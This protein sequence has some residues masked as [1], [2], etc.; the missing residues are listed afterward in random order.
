[1]GGPKGIYRSD[2]ECPYH[3]KNLP[4]RLVKEKS[5]QSLQ[6]PGARRSYMSTMAVDPRFLQPSLGGDEHHLMFSNASQ[7]RDGLSKQVQGTTHSVVEQNCR[8]LRLPGEIRNKIY[9]VIF[10]N[11][12]IPRPH[13]C[14]HQSSEGTEVA[15]Q[16]GAACPCNIRQDFNSA[17]PLLATCRQIRLEGKSLFIERHLQTSNAEGLQLVFAS[18]ASLFRRMASLSQFARSHAQTLRLTLCIRDIHKL[19]LPEVYEASDMIN[20]EAFRRAYHWDNKS[21]ILR[22]WVFAG[23]S[24][25]WR[26]QMLCQADREGVKVISGATVLALDWERMHAKVNGGRSRQWGYG[27]SL[28][29]C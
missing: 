2:D 9:Q 8:L 16:A 27:R 28:M 24:T 10:I 29:G 23:V 6:V 20:H 11:A 19:S 5:K 13:P 22:A 17:L 1:M 4:L 12:T 3:D 18:F 26:L 14:D 25:E 7:E 15:L 21:R